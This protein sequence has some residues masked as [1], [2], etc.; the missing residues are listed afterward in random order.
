MIPSAIPSA[1]TLPRKSRLAA[2]LD[3]FAV[4]VDPRDGPPELGFGALRVEPPGL[5]PQ[6]LREC[7]SRQAIDYTKNPPRPQ[8]I[9][10]L[11]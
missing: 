10:N 5:L 2:L 11:R 1:E 4:M 8:R 7:A 3:R 6:L 9:L